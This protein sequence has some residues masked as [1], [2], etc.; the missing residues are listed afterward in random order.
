MIS[1]VLNVNEKSVPFLKGLGCDVT[2]VK[3][4][5]LTRIGDMLTPLERIAGFVNQMDAR[6][7]EVFGHLCLD[8]A[9]SSSQAGSLR[10]RKYVYDLVPRQCQSRLPA[11]ESMLDQWYEESFQ[12]TLSPLVALREVE[13][14]YHE[15]G[16]DFNLDD[17]ISEHQDFNT[18]HVASEHAAHLQLR[19]FMRL[20]AAR[21]ELETKQRNRAYFKR[22]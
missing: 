1:F 10:A 9:D 19:L 5:Y 3:I 7:Q 15:L 22:A 2:R 20:L 8:F 13:P 18:V 17:E 4:D 16:F 12:R 11:V 14:L 21:Q 6:S